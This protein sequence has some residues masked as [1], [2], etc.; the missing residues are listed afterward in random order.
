MLG[1]E[2]VVF[3]GR[4]IVVAALAASAACS[5]GDATVES[6]QPQSV[7]STVVTATKD[8]D[9]PPSSTASSNPGQ[10]RDAEVEILGVLDERLIVLSGTEED[11]C[12][13]LEG[14]AGAWLAAHELGL[15]VEASTGEEVELDPAVIE[16]LEVTA[17]G[18]RV[19]N[20]NEF[21]VIEPFLQYPIASP[22]ACRAAFAASGR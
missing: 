17:S 8:A 16:L 15:I 12:A 10:P 1:L 3:S 11:W 7:A 18:G 9:G 20:P 14:S 2:V 5:T 6:L 13:T 21:A 4:L 22:L 19:A